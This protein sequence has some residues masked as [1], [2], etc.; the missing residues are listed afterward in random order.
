M[1]DV[2]KKYFIPHKGNEHKPHFLRSSTIIFALSALLGVEILFLLQ[3]FVITPGTGFLAEI[4][5]NVLVDFSNA[6]RVEAEALPLRVNG[7][8]EEAARLKADDMAMNEYFSHNSPTGKTPWDFLREAGY[9]FSKAGENLAVNFSDSSDVINA[10]MNSESHRAN[11]LNKGFTEI[12]IAA[13]EGIYK[14]RKAVYVVQFFGKP[15]LSKKSGLTQIALAEENNEPILSD[16]GSD[17]K[18]IRQ[19]EIFI[20]IQEQEPL[21]SRANESETLLNQ[22]TPITPASSL[23]EKVLASPNAV[24]NY[25]YLIVA[26]ITALSVAMLFVVN[27]GR[28]HYRLAANG[29]IMIFFI[30]SL[31]FLNKYLSS[32]GATIF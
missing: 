1:K 19:T 26:A 30:F 28:I 20:E 21:N 22:N 12:G 3:I 31:I 13:K 32:L 5:P 24:T 6:K 8:L 29:T 4:L 25:F 9:S 16:E 15:G 11:V 14:G 2:L 23:K 17:P 27:K 10:W 7:L 18:I